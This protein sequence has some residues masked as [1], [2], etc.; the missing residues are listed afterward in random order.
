MSWPTGVYSRQLQL[1][2]TRHSSL[3]QAESG[4]CCGWHTY[5]D[6]LDYLGK[7]MLIQEPKRGELCEV[8]TWAS[9]E[10]ADCQADCQAGLIM[11]IILSGMVM[12]CVTSLEGRV[13]GPARVEGFPAEC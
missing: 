13:A 8:I 1:M 10:L 9:R 12:P 6:S 4:W 3:P 7:A 2:M 11:I 5:T